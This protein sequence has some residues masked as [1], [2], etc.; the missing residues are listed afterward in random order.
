MKTFGF[1]ALCLCGFV[2]VGLNAQK[3]SLEISDPYGPHAI[4]FQEFNT[5]DKSRSFL[6]TQQQ[7]ANAG[8]TIFRPIQ[9]CVWYPAIKTDKAPLTYE[10][11]FFLK[12]HEVGRTALSGE[13]KKAVIA[14]FLKT[15]PVQPE[16]L[17]RELA[18]VMR[19]VKNAP[20]NKTAR[21]PILIYGP[22]WWS[23][24]Y[25]NALMFEFLASHGYIVISSPSVGP[26]N[27]EMPISRIGVET[28]ARDMEFLLSITDQ[29]PNADIN[30]ISVAGFSLGGLSNVL[31]MARNTS[32]DAWIG[33]DPSIHEAY[34]FF[35]ESPF[36]DYT[37][38]R[39]PMLFINS[40]GYMKGLPFYDQL[41]YSDAYMV[42]LPQ[43][44]HTDLAS[45]F[46]KLFGSGKGEEALAKRA[47]GYNAMSRYLLAFL[48]GVFKKQYTYSEMLTHVFQMPADTSFVQFK[49]KASLPTPDQLFL[50]FEEEQGAGMADFLEKQIPD[51]AHFSY[52]EKDLQELIFRTLESGYSKASRNLMEWYGNKYP[53]AFHTEVSKHIDGQKMLRMFTEVYRHN[54]GCEF[55]YYQLNHTGHILSMGERKSEALD[56][57]I[58][59]TQLNPKNSQAFFNLGIG[60]Y[61]L[62]DMDNAAL[63]FKKCLELDPDDRYRGLAEGFLSKI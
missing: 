35:E 4:G 51:G 30:R 32:V 15:D 47:R 50:K 37:R 33:I 12:A 58:L 26:E 2:T 57:F 62:E 7:K 59:N 63:N 28:Q 18:A 55:N 29:F 34:E 16:V 9:V 22:S 8:E 19:A 40:M 53:D 6:A 42:N 5:F 48:D 45:Q 36:E 10:A 54:K 1:Y 41:V 61:R 56:Y 24:A 39:K 25:E 20:F 52:P 3:S 60:Y 43:L 14:E 38:F 44:E 31:M 13:R 49:S 27:R 11:Y 46:I 21:F 23:T 17:E